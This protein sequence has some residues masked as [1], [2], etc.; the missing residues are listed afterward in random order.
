MQNRTRKFLVLS[1]LLGGM[2][3]LPALADH[4]S[5]WGPGYANMPND[6]HNARKEDGLDGTAWRD[7]VQYGDGADTVNRYLLDSFSS[8]GGSAMGGGAALAT[9][10]VGAGGGGRR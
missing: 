10:R 4:M 1:A 2:N 5:P 6:I 9:T 3:T 8:Q 7:F